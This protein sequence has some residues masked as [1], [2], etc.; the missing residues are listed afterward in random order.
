MKEAIIEEWN[1][2]LQERTDKCIG[3]FK[4]RLRRVTE[5]EAWHIEQ[6]LLENMVKF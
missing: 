6:Y 2:I 1:K 5:V 3:A 4:A